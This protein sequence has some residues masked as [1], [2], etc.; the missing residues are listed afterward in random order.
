MKQQILSVLENYSTWLSR[1]GEK[2]QDHQDFFASKVGRSAK[3]LYYK[4]PKIGTLAVAPMVACEAFFP[5]TRRLYFPKQRLPISDAHFAMGFAALYRLTQNESHLERSKHFLQVL[6]D[7]RC[8]KYSEFCWGYPF[9]W[10]TVHSTIEAG[11]PLITTTPYCFEAFR[12]LHR[13][14]GNDK[15]HEI[16]L[17]VAKH[18]L[19]DYQ[20]VPTGDES[21]T[22]TYMPYGRTHVVN[23]SSYRAALLYAGWKLTGEDAYKETA[24]RNIRFVLES[25]KPDGSWPYATDGSRDF[26]DHFHTCFVMKGLIKV[27]TFA[28]NPAIERALEKGIDYYLEHLFDEDGL[29]K[30]FA[31][32][33]RMTVYKRELYD[34]AECINLG[35][36]L[37]G[38][39][40]K[41]DAAVDHTVKEITS[42]WVQKSGAFR[43]RKLLV[44][45]DNVPMHRWGG[46]EMFRSLALYAESCC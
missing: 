6:E 17:S 23:A 26:V 32:A 35:V 4:S 15:W 34:C 31:I 29:P 46:S 5:W 24:D 18:A 37:R 21:A 40:S 36:L 8:P 30:P 43:S 28:P 20:D 11:T 2:S 1:F 41:L 10:Q 25:Q 14:D 45:W 7:T 12:D 22:C 44:G 33:P 3:N 16:M 39:N 38:T 27:N 13:I 19:V 42:N 9:N